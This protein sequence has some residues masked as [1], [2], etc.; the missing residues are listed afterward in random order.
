M[1]PT[2]D[3]RIN[4]AVK[5]VVA[6]C[7]PNIYKG[8]ATEYCVY[9]YDE[10]PT[11]HSESRPDVTRYLIQ[12]NLY[13]PTG[14]NPNTKKHNLAEALYGAGFTYPSITNASDAAGQHYAF[15]CEGAD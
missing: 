10:L 11:L 15:D 1:R 7:K 9:T 2:I 5:T 6:E 13:L 14:T 12:V 8:T 3:E 4:T